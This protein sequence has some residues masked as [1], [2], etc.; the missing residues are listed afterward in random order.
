MAGKVRVLHKASWIEQGRLGP[1]IGWII[2]VDRVTNYHRGIWGTKLQSHCIN[3]VGSVFS[4][5]DN[6]ESSK[7]R[8]LK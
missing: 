3:T 6:R 5:L 8:A 2:I 1:M 4:F 7:A